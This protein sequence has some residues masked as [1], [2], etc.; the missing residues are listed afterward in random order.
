MKAVNAAKGYSVASVR[1]DIR[2][3]FFYGPDEAGS[4]DLARK[5][6]QRLGPEGDAVLNLSPVALKDDPGRLGD[7]ASAVS[8]FGGR[9]VIRVEGVG[10]ESIE[11]LTLLLG[12]PVA[13]NPVVMTAGNLRKGSKLLALV[14]A[15]DNALVVLSYT[16]SEAEIID[17]ITEAAS[18]L[19]LDPTRDAVSRLASATNGDRGLI[20]QELAK[21][22]LYLDADPNRRQR[23]TLEHLAEIGAD[24]ADEDFALL[25][26]AV[27]G[28]R[29]REA[30]IELRRLVTVG[31]SGILLLRAVARR[32]YLLLDLRAEVD[33]GLSVESA[34]NAARPPVFWKDKPH[35]VMQV[36]RWRTSSIRHALDRTLAAERAIKARRSAGDV[37]ASQ[38]LLAVAMLGARAA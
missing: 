4:V 8:M 37:L 27:S 13:G 17:S 6:V 25:I 32:L 7:E 3:A 20:G 1:P 19:G 12:L 26:H 2:L 16:A 29:P 10:D 14:E 5:L 15:A 9:L 21:L 38:A 24:I 18:A 23:L 30:D 34:V 11:A 22:A 33:G 28:G 36:Q 35:L 31:I